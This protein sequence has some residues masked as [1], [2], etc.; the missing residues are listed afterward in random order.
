MGQQ[1]LSEPIKLFCVRRRS[2]SLPP[3]AFAAPHQIRG[4]FNTTNLLFK[5]LLF[6]GGFIFSFSFST[7]SFELR[8]RTSH[9]LSDLVFV[10]EFS[11]YR[12]I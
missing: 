11:F 2:I 8:S 7:T 1:S 10:H 12:L 6:F 3:A 5:L 9:I 4:S